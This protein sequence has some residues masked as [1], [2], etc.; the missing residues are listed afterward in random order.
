MN[1]QTRWCQVEFP[2]DQR[3]NGWA[4]GRYLQEAGAPARPD[5]VSPAPAGNEARGMIPCA[6]YVGQPMATC[7]FRVSRGS[8]GTASVWVALPGGGERY[9]DFREGRI[10]GSDP[11]K[12]VYQDRIGDLNVI[13]IDGVERYELPDAVLYGG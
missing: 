11:G 8:G 12:K 13:S 9:L 4:S 1:G 2:G 6:M 7:N 3:L 5:P 10:V